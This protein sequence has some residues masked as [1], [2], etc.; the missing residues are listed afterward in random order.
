M[1]EEIWATSCHGLDM[2]PQE[3]RK[4]YQWCQFCDD[5]TDIL[6][7]RTD[8]NYRQKLAEEKAVTDDPHLSTYR[9]SVKLKEIEMAFNKKKDEVFA[10]FVN[11]DPL[12][13]AKALR[14]EAT[15][16]KLREA[17]TNVQ[18]VWYTRQEID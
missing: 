5:T 10:D 7:Y 2:T 17:E 14:K 6:R 1:S 8:V 16:V 12:K 4:H 9:K 13:D 11:A 18:R 3:V 15:E